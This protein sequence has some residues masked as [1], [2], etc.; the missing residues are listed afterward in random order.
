MNRTIVF[1]IMLLGGLL[2]A[3]AGLGCFGSLLGQPLAS[4]APQVGAT[5]KDA[6]MIAKKT[7][8]RLEKEKG[9]GR[10]T[11]VSAKYLR[12]PFAE[13]KTNSVDADAFTKFSLD[14]NAAE[15]SLSAIDTEAAPLPP[16]PVEPRVLHDGNPF[17]PRISAE[18]LKRF[19]LAYYISQVS[20]ALLALG[21]V[22]RCCGSCGRKSRSE[23]EDGKPPFY[24]MWHIVCCRRFS[25]VVGCGCTWVKAPY[26]F[27][28]SWYDPPANVSADIA[29]HAVEVFTEVAAVFSKVAAD[30][31]PTDPTA[32]LPILLSLPR[33]LP[34]PPSPTR[35]IRPRYSS[36]AYRV[37]ALVFWL[38]V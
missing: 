24:K 23:F 10:D 14:P 13:K 2:T 6:D 11:I 4:V 21:V 18:D 19:E 9:V 26:W 29:T 20:V 28:F 17:Q 22:C 7:S 34:V 16:I 38:R 31:P 37:T 1:K 15:Q 36:T 25:G 3:A 33:I 8:F 35:V 27:N 5:V 12:S 32:D 30:R